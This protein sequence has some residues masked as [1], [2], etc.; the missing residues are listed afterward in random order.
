MLIYPNLIRD[1]KARLEEA[2]DLLEVKGWMLNA[3]DY[4][5]PNLP[6]TD[7]HKLLE[8]G[9]LKK[10]RS[11]TSFLGQIFPKEEIYSRVDQINDGMLAWAMQKRL[12]EEIDGRSDIRSCRI[13]ELSGSTCFEL[14]AGHNGWKSA[15]PGYRTA[16][17]YLGSNGYCGRI[18]LHVN[19]SR[20]VR[21]DE[22]LCRKSCNLCLR[23]DDHRA[24]FHCFGFSHRII[25]GSLVF[26]T[27][28]IY[29]H[30]GT[31]C[32]CTALE[33]QF[34]A[35]RIVHRAV[36]HIFSHENWNKFITV[37][38]SNSMPYEVRRDHGITSPSLYN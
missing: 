16:E 19:A 10:T 23:Y 38:Y 21:N 9:L 24:A 18:M 7:W 28:L 20:T 17:R 30:Y 1:T 33:H 22:A 34:G 4:E 12:G 26:I 15:A 2:Y 3:A 5:D 25:L 35:A 27:V 13:S 14:V 37:M 32:M 11:Y 6:G 36:Y 31:A 29:D 8:S